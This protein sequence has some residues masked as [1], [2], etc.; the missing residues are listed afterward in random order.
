MKYLRPIVLSIIL[1]IVVSL[2]ISGRASCISGGKK[3][4]KVGS[5]ADAV[6]MIDAPSGLTATV[7]SAS[8]IDLF[9]QDNSG[10]MEDGFEIERS[11]SPTT[12]YSLLA[13]VGAN[14][15]SYSDT[16]VAVGFTYYY[17]VR[18]Y[19]TV[20][21]RS[22]W[23][24]V[25][26]VFAFDYA[27]L[28]T[29]WSAVAAGANCTLALAGDGTLWALGWNND[30]Q[31]G[32]GD[33]NTRIVP[34]LIE[35]DFYYDIFEDIDL[36][37]LG[38][39]QAI[40][41]KT[42]GTLWSWGINGVGQLGLGDT[43][44]VDAPFPV[45]S[46]VIG[47][48]EIDTDWYVVVASGSHTI[49]LKTNGTI[50]SWGYNNNGQLG[51]GDTSDR[52]TPS[53]VGTDSDWSVVAAGAEAYG[54]HTIAC[55]T[56]GTLWSWGKNNEGQLGLGD[57]GYGTDR[58]TPTQAGTD[59]GWS[60]VTAGDKHSLGIKTNGTL[61]AWGYNIYGQLGR[62]GDTTIPGQ[63]GTDLD[64]A[65]MTAGTFYTI[66]LKTNGTLWAWGWNQYGQLGL[67]DNIDRNTPSQIG[68]DSNWSM[69]T[70]GYIHSIALKTNRTV[71]AWGPN[72]NGM[73]GLGD[74]IS[75]NIPCSWGSPTPP[76]PLNAT[77]ISSLQIDLSWTDN[78]FNEMGFQIERKT[79][80]DTDYSLLAT[81]GS[82]VTL[83]SD[84]T[85]SPTTTYYYR[86]RAYNTF[87]DSP[88]SNE[89]NATTAPSAPTAL[90]ATAISPSQ[91]DLAW[92]NVNGETGYKIERKTLTT[93]YS[94]LA[95]VGSDVTLYSDTVLAPGTTFY[96][97]VKAY[98]AGGNSGYS[99]EA[100][101]TTPEGPPGTPAS[102]IA[103]GISTIT[104]NLSWTDVGGEIGYKIERSFGAPGAYVQI[105]T[106]G[107]NVT[108]YSDTTVTPSNTYYYRVRAYNTFGDSPYSNEAY[109]PPP[110]RPLSGITPPT[111]SMS[112]NM[113]G[114]YRF[115]PNVN[116]YIV[117]LGRYSSS[118][119]ITV[120]LWDDSG[121]ELARVTVSS[122]SGWQW[123]TLPTPINVSAGTFYRVSV[124][125]NTF[126]YNYS[127]SMPTTRGN[128]TISESCLMLDELDVFPTDLNTSTMYGW[129]DI[130][131]VAE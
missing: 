80:T 60:V 114:G 23:S 35:V 29:S 86:V 54:G 4:T 27:W 107:A 118:G 11:T 48:I 55:K 90:T 89:T 28:P 126:Y 61:W 3:N 6:F 42:D 81:V 104:I 32:L 85:V 58:T 76:L 15:T 34:T 79:I 94:L 110:L 131:F 65:N 9:W 73:L 88:F 52:Y 37:V 93:N 13:T 43:L 1:G 113:T 30:G 117:G 87:G 70:A 74:T 26:V 36:V 2:F 64:W 102:L 108:L 67:G 106:V 130:E 83:Y 71:W 25:A 62:G 111:Q 38:Q 51:L 125:G 46:S 128:I 75:R 116:G 78:S 77:V 40:A 14:V 100:S 5:S 53:L 17:R 119:N 96:Y 45:T 121:T 21:D 16:T 95:T 63:I 47:Q 105:A 69:V 99:P 72:G 115:S 39:T 44:S 103:S 112:Y 91:I 12:G 129:A 98:N 19:N 56:N 33:T 59:S 84:T 57:A 24:N 22:G 123:V 109:P 120:I 20:G 49:G 7:V 10:N 124:S 122:N 92:S 82:N 127:L 66:G 68:S 8:Q 101:A 31:L 50:W 41:R 97:R 18:A